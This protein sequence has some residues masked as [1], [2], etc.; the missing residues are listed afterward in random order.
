MFVSNNPDIAFS[1]KRKIHNNNNNNK[2][3]DKCPLSVTELQR[4]AGGVETRFASCEVTPDTRR[5]QMACEQL[6]VM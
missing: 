6:G 4:A 2:K 5:K 1:G 3:K